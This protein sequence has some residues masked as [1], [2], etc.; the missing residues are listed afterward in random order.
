MSCIAPP[1]AWHACWCAEASPGQEE[2]DCHPSAGYLFVRGIV[3]RL[4]VTWEATCCLENLKEAEEVLLS[5]KA[6]G[7]GQE[8]PSREQSWQGSHCPQLL[9]PTRIPSRSSSAHEVPCR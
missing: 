4:L 8:K 1:E 2:P 9:G 3:V 6:E 5:A 7:N